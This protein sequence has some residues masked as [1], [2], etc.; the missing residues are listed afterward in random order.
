MEP[1]KSRERLNPTTQ[2]QPNVFAT[3]SSLVGSIVE[4]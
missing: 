2:K 3:P 4:K 1:E